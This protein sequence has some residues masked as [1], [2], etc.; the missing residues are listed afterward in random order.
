MEFSKYRFSQ[1]CSHDYYNIWKV[2]GAF[3]VCSRSFSYNF[4]LT[5]LTINILCIPFPMPLQNQS[6]D[7]L[8]K[9]IIYCAADERT[10]NMSELV[11]RIESSVVASNTVGGNAAN[12]DRAV[13]P[14]GIS[15]PNNAEPQTLFS[16]LFE[17]DGDF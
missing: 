2:C 3:A 15:T 4:R 17:C 5:P 11:S 16:I 10:I 13:P 12:K 9:I 6:H 1:I 7:I 8:Q 14:G